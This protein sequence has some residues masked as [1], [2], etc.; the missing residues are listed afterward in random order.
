[1]GGVHPL[2]TPKYLY[3]STIFRLPRGWPCSFGI[4]H[5]HSSSSMDFL[6]M[7]RI[8]DLLKLIESPIDV[9]EV[10]RVLKMV[11]RSF[12][13]SAITTMSSQK[14]EQGCN[15][16]PPEYLRRTLKGTVQWLSDRG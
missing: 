2:T 3:F 7:I 11:L 16:H 13:L 1:M 6:P 12:L 5:V 15:C 4:D 8:S 10:N 9:K 14:R